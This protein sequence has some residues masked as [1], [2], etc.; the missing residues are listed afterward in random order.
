MVTDPS[1]VWRSIGCGNMEDNSF[2]NPDSG[3]S[4]G[5]SMFVSCVESKDTVLTFSYGVNMFMY[6]GVTVRVKKK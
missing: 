4:P 1:N 5:R 6:Y 3:F 2:P